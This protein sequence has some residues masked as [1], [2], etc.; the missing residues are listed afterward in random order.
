MPAQRDQSICRK[1]QGAMEVSRRPSQ[2]RLSKLRTSAPPQ[3]LIPESAVEKTL[4][5]IGRLRVERRPLAR[6]QGVWF[7]GP[8][9]SDHGVHRGSFLDHSHD[10]KN[11]LPVEE[12]ARLTDVSRVSTANRGKLRSESVWRLILRAGHRRAT[13]FSH[14]SSPARRQDEPT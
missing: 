12:S 10:G 5:P 14:A 11:G 3:A 2:I 8:L 9:V 6:Q 1:W 13:S 7:R 4:G